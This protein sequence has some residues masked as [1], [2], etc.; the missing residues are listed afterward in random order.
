M[1]SFSN[2]YQ[3]QPMNVG[4]HLQLS[5][6]VRI[7]TKRSHKTQHNRTF[8]TLSLFIYSIQSWEYLTSYR[9]RWLDRMLVVDLSPTST[10]PYGLSNLI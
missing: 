4:I 3:L 10:V 8:Q 1:H 2:T 6:S 9:Y 5:E 7:I